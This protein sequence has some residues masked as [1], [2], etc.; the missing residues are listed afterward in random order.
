MKIIAAIARRRAA[1]LEIETVDLEA[2]RPSEVLVRIV[3]TG[4]CHTDLSMR[5]QLYPAPLPLVLGNEGAGI[6]EGEATPDLFIP[7]LIT[8]YR[9]G[10][11]PF[12]RLIKFYDFADINQAIQDS[13]HGVTIKPIVRMPAGDL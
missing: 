11:F 2:S 3:A 4:V 9:Q 5:D 8:L 13:E 10:R 7:Q 6:V 12:D 1:P